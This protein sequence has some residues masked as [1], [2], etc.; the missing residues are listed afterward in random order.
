MDRRNKLEYCRSISY[1]KFIDDQFHYHVNKNLITSLIIVQ[2]QGYLEPESTRKLMYW[3]GVLK[4]VKLFFGNECVDAESRAMPD[5][6]TRCPLRRNPCMCAQG[7]RNSH[8][9]FSGAQIYIN[10]VYNM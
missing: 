1:N 6:T 8:N 7:N 2:C 5:A 3:F 4:L 10:N 9:D